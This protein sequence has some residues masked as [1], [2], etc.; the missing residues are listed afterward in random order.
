MYN[1]ILNANLSFNLYFLMTHPETIK[2]N[3]VETV[4]GMDVIFDRETF[5]CFHIVTL[6][7][8]YDVLWKNK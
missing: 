4:R 6:K 5:F 8:C 3:P 1:Y 7:L 2:K